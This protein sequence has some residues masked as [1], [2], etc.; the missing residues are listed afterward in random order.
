MNPFEDYLSKIQAALDKGNATEHTYRPFL[1]ALLESFEDGVMAI[2]EPKRIRCGAPDFILTRGETPIGY[3][4]AKDI[5]ASLD[6]ALKTDQLRR[7]LDSLENLILTDYLEFRWFHGG[8]LRQS[9]LCAKVHSSG[10]LQ[11]DKTGIAEAASLMESF[12][13]AYFLAVATPNELA[14]RMAHLAKL[15]RDA[16]F[17]SFDDEDQGGSLHQQMM[18]FRHSLL[19]DLSPAQFSDMY[20]QTICYGLFAARCSV[21]GNGTFSRRNAVYTLPKTNPFL[22]RMFNYIAGPDLDDRIA[23]AVD[24]LAN[25]L[26]HADLTSVLEQFGKRTRQEDPVVHFYETFLAEY[27]PSMRETRGVYYTPEPVVSYIV[28]SVDHILKTDFGMSE[29]LA[30]AGKVKQMYPH[31]HKDE[32]H[33]VQILDPAAGTGTFLYGV[34]DCIRERFKGNE[35]MWSSYVR[36]HLLPRLFGFELLMAPYAVAHMKLGLQLS[37]SGYDFQSDERLRVYLTNTLE[38]AITSV[39]INLFAQWV[40]EEANAANAI[41]RDAPV[42]VILGNPPYS[43]HSANKGTWIKDLL[44]GRDSLT[45]EST[46]N[47][48]EVDGQPLGERNPKWLNDDY[49]KFIRFGQ[50]KIERTGYGALAFITNHGYLDNPTFCG[51]RQSLMTT[52]DDIYILNLHGNSKKR[53]RGPENEKEENVFDIQQGVAIGIFVRRG[54]PEKGLAKVR[55]AELWGKRERK[56]KCLLESDITNTEWKELSPASPDYL[57]IPY[58]SNMKDEYA[59][60]WSVTSV[61]PIFSST[62]STARNN[63][64]IAFEPNDLKERINNLLDKSKDTESLRKKYGLKDV[65][66]WTLDWARSELQKS[67]DVETYIRPYCYRPF[68]FRFIYYHHAVCER[69]RTD[70]MYHM[71]NTNISLLTHRP[72]SPCKFT[73][74]YCT[75]MIGDQCVAANKTEGGGNSFQF[76]LYLYPDDSP[77]SH[78]FVYEESSKRDNNERR[79]NLAP[80]FIGEFIKQI[81]MEFIHDGK[82]DC[83]S[84]FGPED[85]FAYIYAI[86]HAPSYR[87]RYAEFLRTD[88]PRI[89]LPRNANLFRSLCPLGEELIALH[90]MEKTGTD[91]PKYPIPGANIVDGI[92]YI[93]GMG[94]VWINKTQYFEG[95][96][97]EVWEFQ[98]GGY[99]VCAKWLKDR[100]GLALNFDDLEHYRKTVAAIS[101]TIKI[102][103]AIDIALEEEG[104]WLTAPKAYR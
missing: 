80:D 72:Q 81:G 55:Y 32:I 69:L 68:D 65:S 99:Q 44:R 67:P 3:V 20:A 27:D 1:K 30:Y 76:P 78:L 70:V 5:G 40:T 6:N 96:T 92:H 4:E 25:L 50:W 87:S 35:G 2:N 97:P 14:K 100:K 101:D 102:M 18:G 49:V 94:R 73:F 8:A 41:K 95:I 23:W 53:E 60:F 29:G 82:G 104:G 33:K 103:E 56:Y 26:S 46:H 84:V 48:F 28:R 47:Y 98:I 89:P 37:E 15:I 90:V 85:I 38:E 63:F 34:I 91:L 24:D 52:F 10:K 42:M 62:V 12:L 13:R 45:G 88:F 9:A 51:M 77:Y 19:H 59:R 61:F 93:E 79:P 11:A 7:Y 83:V 71:Q 31:G 58:N 16:I 66:Y 36:N 75:R 17:N 64:S 86:L 21:D 22:R 54:K 74:A 43:G 57:F 39:D